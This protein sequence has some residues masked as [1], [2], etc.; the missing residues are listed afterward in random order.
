MAIENGPGLKMYSLLKMG[1]FQP[2]YVSLPEGNQKKWGPIFSALSQTPIPELKMED[3]IVGIFSEEGV[4][5]LRSG[6][7]DVYFV[8]TVVVGCFQTLSK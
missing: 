1:I 5:V 2:A 4:V 7:V 6:E 8:M 3:L